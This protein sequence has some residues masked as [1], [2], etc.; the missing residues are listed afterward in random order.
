MALGDDGANSGS[1]SSKSAEPIAAAATGESDITPVA[2]DEAAAAGNDDAAADAELPPPPSIF[3]VPPGPA[4]KPTLPS[5]E[6]MHAAGYEGSIKSLRATWQWAKETAGPNR[7]NM[8]WPTPTSTPQD[9]LRFDAYG[10]PIANTTAE[11]WLNMLSYWTALRDQ[12]MF[13][14]ARS[15]RN[16]VDAQMSGFGRRRD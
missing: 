1:K 14:A 4:G 8:I 3:Y 12:M 10:W 5:I 15:Q 7:D 9:A 13:G 6:D 2:S 11:E 16:E